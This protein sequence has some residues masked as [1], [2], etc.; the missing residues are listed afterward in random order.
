MSNIQDY[1]AQIL[2][3]RYGR[4]VRQSIHDAIETCY[5]DG[6][7]GAIDLQAREDI[8][9]LDGRMDTAEGDITALQSG[10]VTEL[11]IV[12]VASTVTSVSDM[13]KNV[14]SQVSSNLTDGKQYSA[15]IVWQ[16][17]GGFNLS[18]SYAS[19]SAWFEV[20]SNNAMYYGLYT[21]STQAVTLNEAQTK[22]IAAGSRVFIT[23]YDSES[24][25]YTFPS[26]GYVTLGLTSDNEDNG[27]VYLLSSNNSVLSGIGTLAKTNFKANFS[28]YVQKGM[29]AYCSQMTG[30]ASA[31]FVPL[32]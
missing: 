8:S 7:A 21:A 3:A 27:M 4:D 5:N 6:R 26:D 31:F 28:M 12:S 10:K 17:V 23:A 29:K 9:A 19:G 16:G 22:K 25:A 11:G 13:I 18:F 15:L 32:Q 1:L 20:S 30:G 24:N 2:A 14:F